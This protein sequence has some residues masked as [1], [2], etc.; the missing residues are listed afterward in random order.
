MIKLT[1]FPNHLLLYI[2]GYIDDILGFAMISIHMRRLLFPNGVPNDYPIRYIEE[3]YRKILYTKNRVSRLSM[4]RIALTILPYNDRIYK[5][6]LDNGEYEDFKCLYKQK[7][8][9][10]S[11]MYDTA[12]FLKDYDFI[13]WIKRKKYFFCLSALYV[14]INNNDINMIIWLKENRYI[15]KFDVCG[16]VYSLN[17][18]Y[19]FTKVIKAGFILEKNTIESIKVFGPYEFKQ[20]LHVYNIRKKFNRRQCIS[21]YLY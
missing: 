16:Q 2:A 6:F 7:K 19:L 13:K 5:I 15:D 20:W 1:N 4:L 11:R 10:D 14:A 9:T 3:I 12:V 21:M 8:H 18:F 17:N